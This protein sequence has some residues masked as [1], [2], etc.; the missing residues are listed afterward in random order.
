M[1]TQEVQ[2]LEDIIKKYKG[3]ELI[4]NLQTFLKSRIVRRN[5]ATAAS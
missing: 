5:Q 1:E 2:S 3:Q 4:K